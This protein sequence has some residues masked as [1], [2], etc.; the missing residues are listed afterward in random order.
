MADSEIDDAHFD[1]SSLT[2]ASSGTPTTTSSSSD[3]D[4]DEE[5]ELIEDSNYNPSTNSN[6]S[7]STLQRQSTSKP[8]LSLAVKLPAKVRATKQQVSVFITYIATSCYSHSMHR[9]FNIYE[10]E[11]Y[12]FWGSF[13]LFFL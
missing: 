10:N 12:V 1:S 6:Q 2:D 9:L 4:E 7:L 5:D 8:K 11:R 3:P 13:F